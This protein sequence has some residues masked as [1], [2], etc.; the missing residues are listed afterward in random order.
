MKGTAINVQP[1]ASHYNEK[2]YKD[3][4]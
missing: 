2:Y 4:K 1:M 3:P